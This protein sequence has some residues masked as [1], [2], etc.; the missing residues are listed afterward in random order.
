MY[1]YNYIYTYT[2]KTI[3]TGL[4]V[5]F[6][7]PNTAMSGCKTSTYRSIV[8]LKSWIH[9]TGSDSMSV[10]SRDRIWGSSGKYGSIC[11][12][13]WVSDHDSQFA[14]LL[15]EFPLLETV[16]GCPNPLLSKDLN[17]PSQS[18]TKTRN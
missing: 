14:P 17:N 15:A 16:G 3:C 7:F 2:W 10:S 11:G 5:T 6:F 4:A 8:F 9:L 12:Q 13:F 1:A 18:N